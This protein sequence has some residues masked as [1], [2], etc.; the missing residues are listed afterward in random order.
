MKLIDFLDLTTFDTVRIVQEGKLLFIGKVNDAP[1]KYMRR[2]II[3]FGFLL[4][5]LE[6]VLQIDI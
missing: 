4:D 5:E 1:Y 3:S 6:I 2:D